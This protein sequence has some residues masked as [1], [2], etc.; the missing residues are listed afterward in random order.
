[1][2]NLLFQLAPKSPQSIR[3]RYGIIAV[4]IG[5]MTMVCYSLIPVPTKYP[6]LLY[7][8]EN[9][10]VSLLFDRASGFVAVVCPATPSAR[11]M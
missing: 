10:L 8:P 6:F 2:E 7:I 9:F 5:L 3:V 11:N 1:M 4:I